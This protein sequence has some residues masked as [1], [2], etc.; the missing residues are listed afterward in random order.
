MLYKHF[1]QQWQVMKEWEQKAKELNCV[2]QQWH[3]RHSLIELESIFKDKNSQ[4]LLF[5]NDNIDSFDF[6]ETCFCK[7]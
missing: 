4:A 7:G 3:I 5:G 1:P 2:N 6:G